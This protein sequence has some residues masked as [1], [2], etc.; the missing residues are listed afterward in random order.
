VCATWRP[1]GL[2]P[3]FV[4][5]RL[6]KLRRPS[7]PGT[8]S[9]SLDLFFYDL[10]SCLEEIVLFKDILPELEKRRIVQSA[11][12]AGAGADKIPRAAL[13]RE[14]SKREYAFLTAPPKKYVLVSGL[15]RP[16][17]PGLT[18][19]RLGNHTFT[20]GRYLPTRFHWEHEKAKKSVADRI[21]G[22]IPDSTSLLEHY[23]S[24]RV[25]TSGRS[26]YEA[27]ER[28]LDQLDLLRGIW[29]F[30]LN[31]SKWS[32]PWH[33]MLR[34][35]NRL[36]LAPVQALHMADGKLAAD[37]YVWYDPHCVGLAQVNELRQRWKHVRTFEQ[38]V[39]KRL[40]STPNREELEND[41]RR[42]V[43]ALDGRDS[44]SAMIKLWSVLEMLTAS[45]NEGYDATVRRA[46][47]VWNKKDLEIHRHVLEPLR[48]RRNATVHAGKES[49]GDLASVFQLKRYVEQ[50]LI[51]HLGNRF[52]FKTIA[53]SASLLD[54]PVQ[55]DQLEA[56]IHKNER[57]IDLARYAQRYHQ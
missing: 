50:M 13:L 35:A 43:R 41:L 26:E 34:P 44:D 52:G 57:A 3:D 28:A 30:D 37:R 5:A 19:T 16:Y 56:I 49:E 29:T 27:A 48:R 36:L 6:E 23:A 42:Y 25:S 20:F 7:S 10:L 55:D 22:R 14:I 32:A 1:K 21:P 18:K 15:S 40:A 8:G 12:F 17:F 39:R 2:D 9:F 24:V 47:F 45:A 38:W 46:L 51:F 31:Y 4:A 54:H 11:V 53:E 33:L